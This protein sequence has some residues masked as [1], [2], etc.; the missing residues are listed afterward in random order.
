MIGRDARPRQPRRRAATPQNASETA[1]RTCAAGDGQTRTD[2]TVTVAD[3]IGFV[4]LL[5]VIMWHSAHEE[6]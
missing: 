1:H 5:G 6:S 2:Q 4:P 3:A